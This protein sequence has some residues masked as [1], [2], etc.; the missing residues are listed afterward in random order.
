MFNGDCGN[1]LRIVVN[2]LLLLFSGRALKLNQAIH[3][4]KKV[5]SARGCEAYAVK[6]HHF[7]ESK[8]ALVDNMI[9]IG[10]MYSSC[11]TRKKRRSFCFSVAPVLVFLCRPHCRQV[12]SNLFPISLPLLQPSHHVFLAKL[13]VEVLDCLGSSISCIMSTISSALGNAPCILL[14][15]DILNVNTREILGFYFGYQSLVQ[16]TWRNENIQTN[17]N[18]QSYPYRTHVK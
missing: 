17:R 13:P 2:P 8:F 11:S 16:S 12:P 10:R 3:I 9:C 5:R 7:L 1:L 15:C 6:Y 18:H 14:P 4:F